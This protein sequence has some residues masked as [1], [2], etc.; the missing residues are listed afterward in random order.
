MGPTDGILSLDREKVMEGQLRL[1]AN[2]GAIPAERMSEA[3][4]NTLNRGNERV[5]WKKAEEKSPFP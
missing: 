4:T 5:N 1:G 3:R 2:L